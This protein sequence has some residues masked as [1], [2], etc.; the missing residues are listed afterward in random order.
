[1]GGTPAE[2]VQVRSSIRPRAIFTN[3]T[4]NGVG[5][6]CSSSDYA[7]IS[8]ITG[9]VTDG[10]H[11]ISVEESDTVGGAYTAIPAARV[12]GTVPAITTANPNTQ[13]VF[14]VYLNVA[15]PFVRVTNVTTG[16]T[17]GGFLSAFV[18]LTQVDLPAAN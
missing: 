18:F 7:G 3:G 2:S 9:A 6:D 10:T 15:K 17:T 11:T 13:F 14:G 4:V 8:V 12:Q 1:M 16:A 5:I